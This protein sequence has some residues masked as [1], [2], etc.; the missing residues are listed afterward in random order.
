MRSLPNHPGVSLDGLD[1]GLHGVLDAGHV[2]PQFLDGP[3]DLVDLERGLFQDEVD[4]LAKAD[5]RVVEC[6]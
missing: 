5:N 3:A 4:A 6:S 2:D 1:D